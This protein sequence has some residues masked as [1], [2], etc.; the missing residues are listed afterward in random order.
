LSGNRQK[1]G[2]V[3]EEK[4]LLFLIEKNYK[5]IDTNWR[6]QKCEI[7]II[8]S[9]NEELIFIEVKTR[10]NSIIPQEN[11]IS[12]AQQKRITYAADFYIKKIKLI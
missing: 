8:A 3:G 6:Y 9:K 4:A 7:D 12:I 2:K 5:I 10:T 1:I 11:L